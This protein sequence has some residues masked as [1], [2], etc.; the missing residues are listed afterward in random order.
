MAE[1]RTLFD[2]LPPREPRAGESAGAAPRPAPAPRT[3]APAPPDQV[4]APR[5]KAAVWSVG[6]LTRELRGA[7]EAFGR[8]S[9]EGE[10]SGFKRAASGHL[11]FDLVDEEAR[12]ACV[13]WRT[14]AKSAV[15]FDLAEGMQVVAHGRARRLPAAGQ[16]Q[17]ER[18]AP[19]ALG[20]RALAGAVR[21]AQGRAQAPRLVRPQAPAAQAAAHDRRRD[22]PRRRRPARFPAHAQPALAALPRAPGAHAGAGARGGGR[23][24]ARARAPRPERRRRHRRDAAAGARSRTC[25]PSTSCRWRPRSTPPAC[26]SCPG[27]GTR[28]TRRWPTWSPTCARTRPPT[29]RRSSSP[30]ARPWPA[31]WSGSRAG[32]SRRSTARCASRERRLAELAGTRVLRDARWIAV[33]RERRLGELVRRAGSLLGERLARSETHASR[34]APAPRAAQPAGRARPAH[35]APGA[36]R[37]LRRAGAPAG[38]SS[39]A[40][41]T[42]SSWPPSCTPSRRW[43]SSRA[44]TRSR[45]ARATARRWS[46]RP[47]SRRARPSPRASPAGG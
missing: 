4:T 33:E 17:P 36:R 3:D 35:A 44:A 25:G 24:R 7:L 30:S 43:R 10:V 8:V 6:A 39:G 29:R 12:L 2:D 11:Y 5:A 16:L 47:R 22:Q 46:T 23:D 20:R 42:A 31:S 38:C 37:R 34:V 26:R 41:A 1:P 27:S 40:S 9:V 32:C 45:R 28:A 15:R 19:G 13:V 21:G 14:N 18:A